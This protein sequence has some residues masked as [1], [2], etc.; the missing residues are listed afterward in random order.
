[1]FISP[2]KRG[3]T[4]HKSRMNSPNAYAFANY[5]RFSEFFHACVFLTF[6]TYFSVHYYFLYI[7]IRTFEREQKLRIQYISNAGICTFT[8]ER[9]S[10]FHIN[11]PPLRDICGL[12]TQVT[13]LFIFFCAGG[14]LC[15]CILMRYLAL[16]CK[17]IDLI[18]FSF[19]RLLVGFFTP[20]Q[21]SH[22]VFAS[23]NHS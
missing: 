22:C 11:A 3:G 15:A 2:K 13:L 10:H 8:L 1:M 5:C 4:T 7:L 18:W 12:F 21:Y 23:P 9:C 16:A 20:K 17:R 14:K 6:S 19:N